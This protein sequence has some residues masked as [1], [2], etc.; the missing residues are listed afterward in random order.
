VAWDSI[1]HTIT[2]LQNGLSHPRDLSNTT[3]PYHSLTS[4]TGRTQGS[5][6]REEKMK[7]KGMSDPPTGYSRVRGCTTTVVS[8][9]LH[10]PDAP[11]QP[12]ISTLR[13]TC[14]YSTQKEKSL[15]HIFQRARH[16]QY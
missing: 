5:D 11:I 15:S 6:E 3:K 10:G 2:V 1:G 14:D 4:Q 9:Y 8:G 12:T 7:G 13:S 16:G